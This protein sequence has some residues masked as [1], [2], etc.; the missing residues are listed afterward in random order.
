VAYWFVLQGQTFDDEIEGGY[1]WAPQYGVDKNGVRSDRFYWRNLELLQI[2]DVV[3][4]C[5]RQRVIAIASV[6]ESF[7]YATQPKNLHGQPWVNEGRLVRV[8]YEPL[9]TAIDT[10]AILPTLYA[11]QGDKGAPSERKSI[12]SRLYL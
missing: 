1:L 2:A 5:V 9:D 6:T 4:G 7:V 12:Q 3:F 8:A 10:G 11:V